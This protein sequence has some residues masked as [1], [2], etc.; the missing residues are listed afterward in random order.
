L[1]TSSVQQTGVNELA[2]L[3][4]NNILQHIQTLTSFG[5]RV[6]GYDGFYDAADYITSYWESL[7][8]T[9]T[10][11]NF[12]VVTPIVEKATLKVQ[13]PNGT[14][15]EMEVYPLWPNQIN[16]CPYQSPEEG[17]NLIYVSQGLPEDF[18]GLNTEGTF[19]L[20]DFNNRWYWKNAET[21][22]AK[23]VIFLEP[24]SSTCVEAVQKTLS[25]PLDFPRLYVR[26]ENAT[27]LRELVSQQ[28]EAKIW[29]DSRMVWEE[30]SVS[31]LVA[32]IEGSD[33]TLKSEVVVIGAYYD[34]WSIVPQL[35]PGATDSMG[36]AFLLELSR[37]LTQS[38]PERTV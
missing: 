33:P 16:P 34:S 30:K 31:N 29:V 3:N 20:M 36:I 38:R 22:G 14:L 25:V 32:V 15:Y 12:S 28:G 17:D 13:L 2:E 23:G 18:D 1:S 27:L 35:A 24:D 7:G 4:F 10:S 6:T 21:F 19:V 37:L 9:V 5:A 11:E 8:L 26:G